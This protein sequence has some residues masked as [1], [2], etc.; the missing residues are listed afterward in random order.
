MRINLWFDVHLSRP[1]LAH[2][3][4]V[5]IVRVMTDLRFWTGTGWT[6]LMSAIIDLG[7]PVSL[8]PRDIWRGMERDILTPLIPI[9]GIATQKA[10]AIK[11]R[12]A[13][14][15]CQFADAHTT[16]TSLPLRAYLLNSDRV[17][18]IIG[19][20]DALTECQL[21]CDFPNDMAYLEFP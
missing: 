5:R 1:L 20:E 6:P 19:I 3:Q 12:L 18:L 8:I 11:G 7:S 17:P 2:G 15:T 9:R 14:V 13:E 10:A 4:A 21:V 16:S